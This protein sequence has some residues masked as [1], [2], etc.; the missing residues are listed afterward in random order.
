VT[1][2]VE[3][4]SSRTFQ[5]YMICNPKL[6][7]IEGGRRFYRTYYGSD[8]IVLPLWGRVRIVPSRME[9]L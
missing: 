3:K 8:A 5:Q 1:Y 9:T 7:V 6:F 2:I 4:S